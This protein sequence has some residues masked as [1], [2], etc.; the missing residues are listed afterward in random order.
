KITVR[1]GKT[2]TKPIP[3]AITPAPVHQPP[4]RPPLTG[5]PDGVPWGG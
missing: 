5:R 1:A 4:G 3:P 2:L